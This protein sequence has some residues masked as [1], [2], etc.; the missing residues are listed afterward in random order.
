MWKE[1]IGSVLSSVEF[2][3][4]VGTSKQCV[5]L[6]IGYMDAELSWIQISQ[7]KN[8]LQRFG[9]LSILVVAENFRVEEITEGEYVE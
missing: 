3:V 9:S 5:W 6:T 1:T 8:S 7:P 4:P 2:C